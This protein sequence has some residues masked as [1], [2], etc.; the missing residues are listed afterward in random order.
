MTVGPGRVRPVGA[1]EPNTSPVAVRRVRSRRLAV[2]AAVVLFL[3]ALGV[4]GLRALDWWSRLGDPVDPE[5]TAQEAFVVDPGTGA[6]A[7]AGRLEERGLI[8][9]ALYFRYLARS[10]GLDARLQAG[11]FLL[12]PAMST[13]EVI[14][15]LVSGRVVLLRFTVPEGLTVPEVAAALE[16]QEMCTAAEFLEVVER[17]ELAPDCVPEAVWADPAVDKPLQGYLFP[18]TYHVS[19]DATAEDLARVMLERFEAVFDEGRRARA[20]E[21]GMSI[22]E[23]VTLAS[24]IEREARVAEERP[25][26]GSVFHNRL[27]IGMKLDSCPTVLYALGDW[28]HCLTYDDLALEHPYNTYVN[29]GLPPGPICNPGEASIEAA[30][31]PADTDYLYFVA[32]PDGSHHFSTTY[33]EHVNAKRKYGG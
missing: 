19:K 26:I 24:I 32:K 8:R 14:D 25:V 3:L 33:R 7:I 28:T 16:R 13:A 30:L 23:V 12:S 9:N 5:A 18:E 17:R 31:Y 6:E 4:V 11:E 2:A 20:E 21:L 15:C 27:E 29:P 1:L 22:H 10:E